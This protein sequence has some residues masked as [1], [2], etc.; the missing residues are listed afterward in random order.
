MTTC[1]GLAVFDILCACGNA[2]D[3]LREETVPG[4]E[5]WVGLTCVVDAIDVII[6]QVVDGPAIEE[7]ENV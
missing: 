5:P 7:E 1:L 3:A 2:L 4:S 6:D